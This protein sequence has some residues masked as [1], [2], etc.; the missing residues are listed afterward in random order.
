[1]GK[2]V[3]AI[4]TG[5]GSAVVLGFVYWR[6][7]VL[8]KPVLDR[9]RLRVHSDA[10]LHDGL[11]SVSHAQRT[12]APIQPAFEAAGLIRM[13]GPSHNNLE[14]DYLG[15]DAVYEQGP[16]YRLDLNSKLGPNYKIELNCKLDPGYKLDLTSSYVL[17]P[18]A[19]LNL[20]LAQNLRA[21]AVA[22]QEPYSAIVSAQLGHSV[23]LGQFVYLNAGVTLAPS[24][25]LI[26]PAE[27]HLL[28]TFSKQRTAEFQKPDEAPKELTGVAR[29]QELPSL[30]LRLPQGRRP[31]SRVPSLAF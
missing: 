11:S 8:L 6:L 20:E 21:V 24:Q 19:P 12:P 2:F 30:D 1:M 27:R 15:A 25:F 7:L 29:V 13:A 23:D 22:L 26:D 10:A 9:L 18:A 28:L 5:A 16:R 3:L 4:L 14:P 31:V 17:N